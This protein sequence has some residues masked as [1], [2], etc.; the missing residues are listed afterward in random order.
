MFNYLKIL[1]SSK[2]GDNSVQENASG[3]ISRLIGG[4]TRS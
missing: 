2:A 3:S 1:S 4:I